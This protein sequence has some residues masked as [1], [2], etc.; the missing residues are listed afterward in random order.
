M[1][2]I[3]KAH[4]CWRICTD[5]IDLNKAYPRDCFS[6]LK[7]NRFVNTISRHQFM[8]ASLIYNQIK[9]YLDDKKKMIF[10]ID[11]RLYYYLKMPFGL[12]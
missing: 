8:D 3:M 6:L 10:I 2:L 5:F 1:V 11:K 4:G 12:K 7:I 9:M